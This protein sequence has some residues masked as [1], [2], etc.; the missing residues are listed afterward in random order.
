MHRNV[1]LAVGAL[2]I[3]ACMSSSAQDLVKIAG[4]GAKVILENDQ[5]R[6]IELTVAPGKRTGVHSHGDHIIYFLTPGEALLTGP[7]KKPVR[8]S[9]PQGHIEWASPVTHDTVNVG[10]AETRTLIIELK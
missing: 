1:F 9:I 6:V 10:S 3:A 2:A 5:V 4:P 8:R 7:D